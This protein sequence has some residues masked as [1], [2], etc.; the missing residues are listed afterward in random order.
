MGLTSGLLDA[1][2]LSRVLQAR[3]QRGA[4]DTLL[5]SW[6]TSRRNVFVNAV[7]P[8]SRKAYLSMQDPDKLLENHPML[9]ALKAGPNAKPPAL[10]TDVT[11]LEGWVG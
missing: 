1:A 3:I 10:A 9:V 8:I 11:T 4:P 6:A 5:D 7:D 2:S